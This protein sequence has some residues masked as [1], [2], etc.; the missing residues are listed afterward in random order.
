VSHEDKVFFGNFIGVLAVL[1]VIA[2][3]FFF[4]ANTVTEDTGTDSEVDARIEAKTLENIKPVGQV[5]VGTVPAVATAKPAA[6][7]GPRTGKEIV[8]SHC[9]A[10]HGTGV[11]G[12]PKIGDSAAWG[13]RAKQ[14]IATLL[15]HATHGFKAMPPKGTCGDCS[16]QELKN[17]IEYM[18][19]KSGQ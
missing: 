19:S 14:G 13:P 10:C 7:A 8:A 16:E 11:A 12:A 5:N 9:G 6:A 15:S 3:V 1:V 17:A 4:L 2:F 18:L